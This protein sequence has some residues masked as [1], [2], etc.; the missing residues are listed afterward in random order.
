MR[1]QM[2]RQRPVLVLLL[3]MLAPIL[4]WGPSLMAQTTGTGALTGTVTDASGAVI[5]DVIVTATNIATGQSRTL[6]TGPNGLY[7]FS[8]LPPGDYRVKFSD[9]GFKITEFPS[10]TVNVTETAV[11]D[12]KLEVGVET[13][14][15]IVNET[16]V[17][18]DTETSAMGTL[19]GSQTVTTLPLTSRNYTQILN[20]SA[21]VS[22]NVNDAT[23]LGRGTQN[24]TSV[25]GL[26]PGSNNYQMDGVTAN[27]VGFLGNPSDQDGTAGVSVPSPDAIEEFKIQTSTYDASY[28]RNPGASVDVVT[29][30]G[31]NHFHGTAFEFLRNPKLNAND[32]FYNLNN[33]QAKKG[34]KQVL[35]QNQ[36][37]GTVGGPIKKDKLLFF[38]SYQGTRQSNGVA[39]QGLAS[40]D[41][42]PIPADRTSATFAADLGAANCG[43]G[44]LIPAPFVQNVAC[45]GSN[46]NPVALE[47]LQLKNADG[48]YYVP[49]SGTTGYNEVQFSSPAHFTEDQVVA[50][51]DYIINPKETLQTKYFY[52]RDPVLDPM[53]EA[54]GNMPG[55]P[56]HIQASNHNALVRL[57][58][59]LS[60]TFTN[61]ARASYQRNA[62][63]LT[64]TQP[65]NSSPA[66]LGVNTLGIPAMPWILF[67]TNGIR[68]FND[69]SPADQYTD[70]YQLGDQIAWSR[71][72]HT[73]RAGGEYEKVQYYT[74]PGVQ[75]GFIAIG[76]FNDFLVGQA[77]N[78]FG[79]LACA[80]GA[81]PGGVP[82]HAYRLHDSYLFV[83][84]DWKV[85]SRLTLN[86]GLRWE[87]D[88]NIADA[89]G[90]L[91]DIW[92]SQ[93]ASA[94]VPS[95]PSNS[96]A[97]YAGYVVPNNFKGTV[98]DGVLKTNSRYSYDTPHLTNFAPRFG[99]AWQPTAKDNL[100][101]RGGFG[102][103]YDRVWMDSMVRSFTANPP[104]GTSFN[105][106]WPNTE[107]L[108]A[109]YPIPTT[110]LGSWAPRY[111]NF[112]TGE[113]SGLSVYFLNPDVH[114][115]LVRSYNLDIQYEFAPTWVLE[116]AY[117]G[118]SGINLLDEYHNY[119]TAE[120]ATPANPVNG[121]TTSTLTN[122]N[123]RVPYLG[124]TPVGLQG[125]AFDGKSNYNSLQV[126]LRK[127]FSHGLTMQA[128]YTWSKNLSDLV[129]DSIAKGAYAANSNN[130]NDFSQQYGPTDYNRPQRLILWYSYDLPS[131]SFNG[132]LGVLLKGWT[133]AGDAAF[134]DGTP[135]TIYD[136]S[137]GTIYGVT[138]NNRV[139]LCPGITPSMILSSGSV[140]SRIN[141]YF[142]N[143]A[144]CAA[145]VVS[146]DGG[147][148]Y[149][150]SGVGTVL[151]PGQNNWD[152]TLMK[153]FK[154]TETQALQFRTEFYD[155]FNHSQFS[156]P[157]TTVGPTLGQITST[158]VNPRIIQFGLKYNF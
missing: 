152:I 13:Q 7:K 112:D 47:I 109:P 127:R 21:G 113:T 145:P 121:L 151:G 58:S 35:R 77:G 153:H 82:L 12:S 9:K 64:D 92:P 104:Y 75:R 69:F 31:T 46:I 158:S 17:G 28:G 86:L 149:G 103:F 72:K 84:D 93:L 128:A 63:S 1:F 2:F 32:F 48:S 66:G 56:T 143:S 99:F 107:T 54:G 94:P 126:T 40:A 124:Y 125:T 100:S 142:N 59:L 129:D 80:I 52:T 51:G 73:L 39:P 71:G 156:N 102:L 120:L 157:S 105:S 106:S 97:A 14:S 3:I 70:Q 89:Y 85:N 134:Q 57:T 42:P 60:N 119:N 130:A 16:S 20:L 144:F 115:P 76:T 150:D 33:P 37:G 95:G 133:V 123:L 68:L 146:A 41:L 139:Q 34:I 108:Q 122:V 141:H 27:S 50:N 91:T 90:N 4:L 147:T 74:N 131:G 8:L 87:F 45:D 15:V 136:T 117:V 30:S 61:E 19:V 29:K 23:A 62:G 6:T 110:P 148:G 96:A 137:A 98:P 111:A 114:D 22:S 38:A 154:L 78:I 132:P 10:V 116:A 155:A 65:P 101:V 88:G 18:V 118:N 44:V 140:E 81:G 43:Y 49:G 26:G 36:F 24:S 11:L 135:L 83:Q 79:C 5:P 67:L 53:G 55:D 25:N 138:S